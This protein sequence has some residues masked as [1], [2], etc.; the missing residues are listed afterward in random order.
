MGKLSD[1]TIWI[2]DRIKTFVQARG[3]QL[4]LTTPR[5]ITSPTAS[6][7]RPSTG[8]CGSA[9][10][11]ATSLLMPGRTVGFSRHKLAYQIL[12]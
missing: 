4:R 7:P 11:S 3:R 8:A 10:R 5:Q 12:F 1:I 9:V 6:S 2:I